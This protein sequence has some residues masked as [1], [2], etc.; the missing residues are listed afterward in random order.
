MRKIILIIVSAMLLL[1]LTLCSCSSEP[2]YTPTTTA[3]AYAFPIVEAML[4]AINDNDFQGYCFYI[5]PNM[6]S[7][8]T[9]E[10]WGYFKDFYNARIGEYVSMQLYDV[11]EEGTTI[12]VIYK[13][14]YTKADEVTVT[15][16]FVPVGETVGVDSLVLDS[17]ELRSAS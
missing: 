5:S 3:P 15:A 1:T 11:Q 10:I 12:T 16:V 4:Q 17:P 8:T 6:A 2:T 9:Q 14:K 13:A 7:R